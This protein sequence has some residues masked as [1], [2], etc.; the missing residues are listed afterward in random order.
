MTIV[1]WF[2]QA[3]EPTWQ[4]MGSASTQLGQQ[5]SSLQLQQRPQGFLGDRLK[6]STTSANY[7]KPLLSHTSQSAVVSAPVDS[8]ANQKVSEFLLVISSRSLIVSSNFWK[9]KLKSDV[10][11]LASYSILTFSLSVSP[12]I[13]INVFL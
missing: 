7:S 9:W 6:G 12:C 13:I 2:L 11:Y 10:D 4:L 5:F 1:V 3:S 8:V